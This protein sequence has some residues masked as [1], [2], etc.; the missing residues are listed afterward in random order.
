MVTWTDVVTALA[1]V[2]LAGA[3][4][5]AGLY[6]KRAYEATRQQVEI[7]R[8]QHADSYRPVLVPVGDPV[9]DNSGSYI[10]TGIQYT[11]DERAH[12]IQIQNIGAGP[13]FNV[14]SALN[15]RESDKGNPNE[16]SF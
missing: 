5:Y 15:G 2:V 9:F 16:Q 3:A 7:V 6:A 13:A 8:N 11:P 14:I 4:I 12:R 1:T 10:L